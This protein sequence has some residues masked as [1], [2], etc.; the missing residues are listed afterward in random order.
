MTLIPTP[1]IKVDR[2]KTMKTEYAPALSSIRLVIPR[3]TT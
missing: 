2:K 1:V 3:H